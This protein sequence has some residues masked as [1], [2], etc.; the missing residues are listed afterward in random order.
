MEL[1]LTREEAAE[2]FDL[3]ENRI[4]D[5]VILSDQHTVIG[6]REDWHNLAVV[7]EGLRSHGGLHESEVPLIF[8]RPLTPAY[9]LKLAANQARNYDL[10]DFLLNGIA[11]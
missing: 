10:F 9:A 1:V 5:L 4:G 11:S 6:R 3:P 8:N 2:A 7:E